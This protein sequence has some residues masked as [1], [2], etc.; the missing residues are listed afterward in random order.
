MGWHRKRAVRT[1]RPT[2]FKFFACL[3]E[4]WIRMRERLEKGGQRKIVG[5]AGCQ[6]TGLYK[7]KS[8]P[9]K[10]KGARNA[11]WSQS[12]LVTRGKEWNATDATFEQ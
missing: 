7:D 4:R 2:K 3:H 8:F 11:V 10:K 5:R 6:T 12:S 1:P 9:W